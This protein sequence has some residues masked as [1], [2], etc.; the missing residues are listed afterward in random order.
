MLAGTG[1]VLGKQLLAFNQLAAT[2]GHS[3]PISMQQ[4]ALQGQPH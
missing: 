3:M 1:C 2:Q 4:L